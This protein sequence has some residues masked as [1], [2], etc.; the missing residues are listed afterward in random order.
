MWKDW[1]EED[2]V[3]SESQLRDII[4]RAA[5]MSE[6]DGVSIA[7][8]RRIAHELDIDPQ[9]VDR[10]LAQVLTE[11]PAVQNEAKSCSPTRCPAA[12]RMASTSMSAETSSN[13]RR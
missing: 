11:E 9:A 6:Q 3:V 8:L 4:E 1:P 13:H 7:E 5:R 12:A 10:A 2:R